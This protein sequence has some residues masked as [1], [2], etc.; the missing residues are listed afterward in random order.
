M[1]EEFIKKHQCY[2]RDCS[3]Y[4]M[5]LCYAVDHCNRYKYDEG[6]TRLSDYE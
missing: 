5:K 3:Q 2:E 1:I 4:N 6:Q